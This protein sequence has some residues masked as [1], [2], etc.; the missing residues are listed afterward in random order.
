MPASM[1]PRPVRKTDA[2]YTSDTQ[3]KRQTSARAMNT[4]LAPRP[5]AKVWPT[6][7]NLGNNMVMSAEAR[8]KVRKSVKKC[9]TVCNR[10]PAQA[11]GLASV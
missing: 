10:R 1:P 2:V 6:A 5:A 7:N 11:I 9:A 3:A 8:V 4:A